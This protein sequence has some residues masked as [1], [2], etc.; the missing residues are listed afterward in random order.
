MDF[1]DP[2]D[3]E[4]PQERMTDRQKRIFLANNFYIPFT[5][6]GDKKSQRNHSYFVCFESLLIS[7]PHCLGEDSGCCTEEDPCGLGDGDCDYDEDCLPLFSCGSNNCKELNPLNADAFDDSDDCCFARR[8]KRK[9]PLF[10]VE[11]SLIYLAK[12]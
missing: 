10:S 1:I 7:V 4:F 3:I 2:D 8:N 12:V 9:C 11:F 6:A 5:S